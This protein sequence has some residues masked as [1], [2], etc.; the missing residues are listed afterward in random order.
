MIIHTCKCLP[1]SACLSPRSKVPRC[2]A[3]G[4]GGK[5][6]KSWPRFRAKSKNMC[7]LNLSFHNL[8]RRLL[9]LQQ[10]PWIYR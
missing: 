3:G 8:C 2:N 5:G 4:G 10:Y 6:V 7:T 1:E 9:V